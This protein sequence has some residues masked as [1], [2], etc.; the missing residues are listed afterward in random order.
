VGRRI[1]WNDNF[2]EYNFRQ[3]GK[4]A[5]PYRMKSR[6]AAREAT[7]ERIVRATVAL[8]DEQ[9]VSSTTFADIAERA[10]VGA[11]TVLRHFPTIGQLVTACG[12]HVAAEMQ[13]PT[14]EDAAILFEGLAGTRPRLERLVSELD[15][16]YSRGAIRLTAAANDRDRIPELD[17]FLQ[18]VDSGIEAWV[19]AAIVDEAP[20]AP[21]ISVLM[22]LCSLSVWQWMSRSALT[23]RQRWAVLVEILLSAID[24][25]RSTGTQKGQ[26]RE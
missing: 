21:M 14:P 9:G 26:S 4:M 3:Y 7:R 2:T 20:S 23:D 6:A 22:S 11:A 8:H 1:L 16:F 17:R 12:E 18:M 10:G 13:P 24:A 5:R 25:V 15:A 19:R